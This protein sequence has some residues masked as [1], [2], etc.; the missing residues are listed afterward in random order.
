MLLQRK[1][2]REG[3]R[4]KEKEISCIAALSYFTAVVSEGNSC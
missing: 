1:K 4:E 2:E 3:G